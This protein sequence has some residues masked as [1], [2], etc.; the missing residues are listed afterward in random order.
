[1]EAIQ[2][3]IRQ[4]LDETSNKRKLIVNLG[5]GY[6]PLPFTCLD[7][8][9][10]KCGYVTFVDIDFRELMEKKTN[11]I[12]NSTDMS[13]HLTNIKP[14]KLDDVLL[15][16]DQYI[17]LACD[18]VD[19]EKLD[20][21]LRGVFDLNSCSI[22]FIA[23]VSITYMQE[24]AANAVIRWAASFNDVRFSL[25]EQLLP[26]GED[27]PF[28]STMIRHFNKLQTPLKS[29]YSYPQLSDQQARFK[30]LGWP[31]TEA[32]NLWS[33]WS[34][35]GVFSHAQRTAID[36][37][38]PFDEWEEFALFALHYFILTAYKV[39]AKQGVDKSV[40]QDETQLSPNKPLQRGLTQLEY[41]PGSEKR[42]FG[43]VYA[44]DDGILVCHGGFGPVTRLQSSSIISRRGFPCAECSNSVP[45]PSASARM[46]HTITKFGKSRH[47]LIGG[48]TSP[49]MVLADCWTQ[50]GADSRWVRN[51][52]IPVGRYRHC[53]VE[54]TETSAS[55]VLLFGG[56]DSLGKVLDNCLCWNMEDGWQ[57]V[58]VK[59]DRP[60]PRFGAAMIRFEGSCDS[61]I[62]VGGMSQN[63]I[64]L[65]DFYRWSYDSEPKTIRFTE[66]S[67]QKEKLMC[68]FGATLINT[69]NG[70]L[71]V[72]GIVEGRILSKSTD[73][74]IISAIDSKPKLTSYCSINEHRP[75]LVGSSFYLDTNN[76]LLIFGGGA[77]CFSFGSFWNLGFWAVVDHGNHSSKDENG[78]RWHVISSTAQDNSK[79][80]Q[81]GNPSTPNYP[82]PI[83]TIVRRVKL[84][85]SKDFERIVNRGQPVILEELDIGPCTEKWTAEYLRQTIGAERVVVVHKASCDEMNFQMKNFS[86]ITQS[87]GEFIDAIQQG[88]RLYLRSLSQAKPTELP[89]D[90]SRDFPTIAADFHL[91]ETMEMVQQNLHSS[92][93]RISG[94]VNMWLHYDVMDNVLC[95]IQGPKRL[96]LYPPSD[97][98]FLEC[99]AGASSSKMDVFK[100]DGLLG[101]THPH[102]AVLKAG[103]VLFIPR[104]WFH[105]ASPTSRLSV[106]VNVFFRTLSPTAY[107][108]GKDVYGNRDI[109]A[110]EQGRLTLKRLVGSFGHLP[111]EVGKF[112]LNRLALEILEHV[113]AV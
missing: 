7:R 79:G 39:N 3:S 88:G 26:D 61:G 37:V 74:M 13:H 107:A 52:G 21:L 4:Y 112:Y 66:L 2:F 111:D 29:I 59:G 48:R 53:A 93:L 84:S 97:V 56:I 101:S 90:L 100:Q 98:D 78:I 68:R 23:E 64:I 95:Q 113:R 76:D 102:E 96:L 103:D 110:Y 108:A 82:A 65:Q 99:P 6:D 77:V 47:I 27:H 51:D 38:E 24:P 85:R 18:L 31:V 73:I 72:G 1:M 15:E 16:S 33:L 32:Q 63:K 87:F 89:A 30:N 36:L 22:L 109:A 8:Y 20:T 10:G 83:S 50:E 81:S 45:T 41:I 11:I 9:V 105:S 54:L 25:L 5:C 46:C 106:A 17:A 42:R 91:P 75:L 70:I 55:K 69:R 40:S 44:A 92:P 14:S 58:L 60:P 43:A 28:A 62:L 34:N 49:S 71:L 12:L 19:M 86:Y 67:V 57:E 104:F 35:P 94:P 80:N